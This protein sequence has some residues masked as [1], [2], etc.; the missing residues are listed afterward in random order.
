MGNSALLLDEP[1]QKD[2][3]DDAIANC[4]EN[5]DSEGA[6]ELIKSYVAAIENSQRP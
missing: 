2:D 5:N 4:L 6:I 3:I 1:M